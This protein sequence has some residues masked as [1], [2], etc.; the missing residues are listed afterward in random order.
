MRK[1]LKRYAILWLKLTENSFI[2]MLTTRATAMV[3]LLGKALRF[4]FFVVFLLT[5]FSK[6]D[7]LATY[8]VNQ[9]LFFYLTFTVIDTTTQLLFREVYRFRWKVVHGEFDLVLVKPVN[10]LFQVLAGGADP[11]DL[12]MLIPY[13]VLLFSVG[14]GIA[15]RGWI[16]WI[17]YIAFVINAL[18]IATGFHIL[19]LSLAIL[20]TEI[21][22]TIMI[23]RDLTSMGRIPITLYGEPVRSLLTF[24]V[25]VGIMMTVPAQA[26][27]GLLNTRLVLTVFL[28]GCAFFLLSLK[29]WRYSLTKYASASS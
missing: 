8:S 3:F 23:Y 4:V 21:D 18:V 7:R 1:T 11:L 14:A 15:T 22:H 12:I 29:V 16:S 13:L 20:T 26:F 28:V 5:L 9:V 27:L 6:T 17:I 2:S 10:S 25:P 19:V 24:A